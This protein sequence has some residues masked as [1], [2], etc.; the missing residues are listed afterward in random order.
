[1]QYN[2][3]Y[4]VALYA[5]RINMLIC[6]QVCMDCPLNYEALSQIVRNY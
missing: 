5:A 2:I 6:V 4:I 3:V 1:M